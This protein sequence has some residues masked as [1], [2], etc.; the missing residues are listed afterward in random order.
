MA[1][2]LARTFAAKAALEE[3]WLRERHGAAEWDAYCERTPWRLWPRV[4]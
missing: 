2:W 4:Y 1:L 3:E